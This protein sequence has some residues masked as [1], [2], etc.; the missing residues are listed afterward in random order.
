ML[1]F[2]PDPYAPLAEAA[3]ERMPQRCLIV[4][5][6]QLVRRTVCVLRA[7]CMDAR[8]KGSQATGTE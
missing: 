4:R 2:A 7:V 5:I 1:S 6:G 3:H 8:L